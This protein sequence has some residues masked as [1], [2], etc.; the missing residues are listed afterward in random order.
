M[1]KSRPWSSASAPCRLEF[2]PSRLLALLLILLGILAAVAAVVSE[3]PWSVSL[4]L[5]ALS[6]AHGAW[7]GRRELLRP[8]CS[9]VIPCNDT[10]ATVDGA[11]MGDLQLQ[12][13]GPL[14]FLQWREADG[15][16][17]RLQ[18]WPDNLAA[19][20]RRELRLA[21]AARAPAHSP[22]SMAP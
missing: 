11:A 20:A 19:D 4:P 9:L 14:A 5:A 17:R 6:A 12:W 18:G 21:M 16:H 7:L 22:R 13:R 8:A 1:A 3:L 15:R 2:K 10:V